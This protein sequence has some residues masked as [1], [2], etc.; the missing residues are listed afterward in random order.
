GKEF[1]PLNLHH[2]DLRCV[3]L[4]ELTH[5]LER[6]PGVEAAHPPALEALDK[7]RIARSDTNLPKHAPVDRERVQPTR[8]TVM[9]QR[10][11]EAIG[12]GIVGLTWDT[13]DSRHRGETDKEVELS[14]QR[15][16]MQIPGASHLGSLNPMPALCCKIRQR[17]V[18]Q[19][20]GQVHDPAKR[21]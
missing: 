15:L 7:L 17:T 18:V 8:S 3:L 2:A 19:Y 10:V 5:Y 20:H 12:C 1:A 14:V 13:D 6:F 4:Q 11:E 9:C 21:R 16:Q